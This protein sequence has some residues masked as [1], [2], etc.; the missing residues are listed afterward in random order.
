MDDYKQKKY[1]YKIQKKINELV[2]SGQS[3]PAGYEH[4][5]KHDVK[6]NVKQNVNS[7]ALIGGSKS[8][9]VD[10][11]YKYK[12]EKYHNKIHLKILEYKKLGKDIPEGY[13]EYFTPFQ[14]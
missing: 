1:E 9:S 12:A 3:C 10:V 14:H 13:S 11:D 4:Y 7:R 8:T 6:Q 5:V 2:K